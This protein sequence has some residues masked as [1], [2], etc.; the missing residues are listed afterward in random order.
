VDTQAFIDEVDHAIDSMRR[1]QRVPRGIY[2]LP[3]Q[4]LTHAQAL[5]R[6]LP[7]SG[8]VL[9]PRSFS[10]AV[11]D[12]VAAMRLISAR[13]T[14]LLVEFDAQETRTGDRLRDTEST[15]HELETL[16]SIGKLLQ[17]GESKLA[18]LKVD[19][20]VPE[21]TYPPGPGTYDVPPTR[22]PDESLASFEN[23]M[24]WYQRNKKTS[25][26]AP[27]SHLEKRPPI[28]P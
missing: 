17:W 2:P 15:V 10:S 19:L 27:P 13:L 11:R 6:R 14:A 12:A 18:R 7:P 24:K 26:G 23:R 1:A 28:W 25:L 20:V 4:M 8:V 21:R 9:F 5:E 22:F 3:R 16:A